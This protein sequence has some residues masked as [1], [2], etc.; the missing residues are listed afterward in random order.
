MI[1]VSEVR[2]TVPVKDPGLVARPVD[3]IPARIFFKR[4]EVAELF[5]C[6]PRTVTALVAKNR[7]R[8]VNVP[9]VGARVTAAS[10]TDFVNACLKGETSGK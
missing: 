4:A 7:L 9:G 6:S 5:S 3:G 2:E 1:H 10:V 8:V